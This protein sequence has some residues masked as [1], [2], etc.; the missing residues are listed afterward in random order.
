MK[1]LHLG[2][3]K[4]LF[5]D[6]QYVSEQLGLNIQY[7]KFTD[8]CTKGG[9]LYNISHK[10]ARDAWIKFQNFYNQFDLIITSDT[11]SYTHL[12]LPTILLV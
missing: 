10:R 12:T 2:F 3:H 1:I 7:L 5:N 11:V 8:G 9:A 6:L 4:G